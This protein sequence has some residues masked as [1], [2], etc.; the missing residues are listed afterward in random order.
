MNLQ[1]PLVYVFS[2]GFFYSKGS[3]IRTQTINIFYTNG[4]FVMTFN[5]GRC[6]F[7]RNKDRQL[8]KDKYPN[9]NHPEVYLLH[10]GYKAFY[11][12]YKVILLHLLPI[13]LFINIRSILIFSWISLLS[14]FV[15]FNVHWSKISYKNCIERTNDHED[16]INVSLKLSFFT[17]STKFNAHEHQWNHKSKKVKT[18]MN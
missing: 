11:Q 12:N 14:W 9:L 8:N 7:L 2:G 15:I 18:I 4:W 16:N 1:V 6:R 3:E 5:F 10:G 17:K 13:L